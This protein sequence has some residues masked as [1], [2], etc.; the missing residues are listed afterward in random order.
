MSTTQK[1]STQVWTLAHIEAAGELLRF[2]FFISLAV[3]PL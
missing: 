3:R 2:Y 1:H